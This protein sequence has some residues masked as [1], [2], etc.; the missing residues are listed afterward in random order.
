MT[1]SSRRVVCGSHYRER[2][3]VDAP[4]VLLLHGLT[5]NAHEWD[6]IAAKLSERSR[7]L[8]AARLNPRLNG[9]PSA[10]VDD[11]HPLAGHGRYQPGANV[12]R[13]ALP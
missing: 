4:P 7:A 9:H 3:A 6:P 12:G 10:G 8:A 1:A 11:P 5:G 2:G 13:S